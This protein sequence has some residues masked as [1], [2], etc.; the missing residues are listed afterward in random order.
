MEHGLCAVRVGVAAG[1]LEFF[2]Q[3]SVL[4]EPALGFLRVALRLLQRRFGLA[5]L[6]FQFVN[7]LEA[8]QRLVQDRVGGGQVRVLGQVAGPE[9]PPAGD[10]ALVRRQVAGDELQHG[11]LAGPVGT[12]QAHVL[13]GVDAPADALQDTLRAVVFRDFVEGYERHGSSRD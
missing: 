12:D 7:A 6:L 11:R 3:P 10:L 5:Q 2:G 9:V 1:P 8:A 4:P 13:A